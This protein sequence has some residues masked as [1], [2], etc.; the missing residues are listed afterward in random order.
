MSKGPTISIRAAVTAPPIAINDFMPGDRLLNASTPPCT[1]VA[2]FLNA[3][4]S[5]C[6]MDIFAVSIEPDSCSIVPFKVFIFAAATSSALILP[7][8]VA[9]SS[10]PLA[11]SL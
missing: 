2:S 10:M 1:T 4:S 7:I 6:P 3:G 11:P 8:A 9:I 5:A